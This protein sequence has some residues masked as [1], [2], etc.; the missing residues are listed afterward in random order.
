MFKGVLR[1]MQE[2]VRTSRYVM[3][4]HGA[5][6]I[7]ADGLTVWDVEH[8]VLSAGII[9][10]QRDRVTGEWKYLIEGRTLAGGRA[11]VV[12]KIGPSGKLVFITAYVL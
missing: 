10:R 3:T 1:R 5:D 12:A 4:V 9:R 6:E 8:C 7:E 11:A 2:L